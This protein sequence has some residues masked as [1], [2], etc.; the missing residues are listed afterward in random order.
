MQKM[1]KQKKTG[2][3]HMN[4]NYLMA[5]SEMPPDMP[6]PRFLADMRIGSTAKELYVRNLIKQLRKK[7]QTAGDIFIKAMRQSRGLCRAYCEETAGA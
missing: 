1:G 6:Y 5:N 4:H 3:M 2:E 7:Q